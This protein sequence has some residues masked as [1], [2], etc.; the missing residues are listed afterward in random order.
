MWTVVRWGN[1]LN[2]SSLVH[3]LSC[4]DAHYCELS[5]GQTLSFE[6]S[7]WECYIFESAT[8][9]HWVD[10]EK[11]FAFTIF[12]TGNIEIDDLIVDH[13]ATNDLYRR[14]WH[15]TLSTE[16][17]RFE[18]NVFVGKKCEYG[19]KHI[20]RLPRWE[21][22]LNFEILNRSRVERIPIQS[23][24]WAESLKPRG[25]N[26]FLKK[27]CVCGS[28][29]VLLRDFPLVCRISVSMC[30]CSICVGMWLNIGFVLEGLVGRKVCFH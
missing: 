26:P 30:R 2:N 8:R 14:H 25:G 16:L 1:R 28:M 9:Q 6:T 13:T 20:S 7:V 3:Q 12:Y 17:F 19:S 22:S 11:I 15:V 21:Y 18:D 23:P 24:K 29:R 5:L 4:W 27:R 10:R